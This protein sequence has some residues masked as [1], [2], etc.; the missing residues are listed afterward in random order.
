MTLIGKRRGQALLYYQIALLF[1]LLRAYEFS[2]RTMLSPP[3]S[4][5]VLALKIFVVKK[6]NLISSS[7]SAIKFSSGAKW[8]N[9]W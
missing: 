5:V 8:A 6:P 3:H 4:R 7:V 1:T 9:D 2:H